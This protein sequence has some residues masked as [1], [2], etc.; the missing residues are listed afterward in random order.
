MKKNNKKEIDR[1]WSWLTQQ[2]EDGE[3]TLYFDGV[4]AQESWFEDEVSPEQFKKELEA[5]TGPVTIWINSPGGDVFAAAQIYN[6]LRNYKGKVTVKIDGIAASAATV[7]AMAGD[8][9][10]MSPVSMMMIHNP[11]TWAAGDSKDLETV[12]RQLDAV[13]ETIINAY[14]TK[15]GMDRDELSRLMDDEASFDVN[16]AIEHKFADGVIARRPIEENVQNNNTAHMFSNRMAVAAVMNKLRKA[17]KPEEPKGESP[18]V[19]VVDLLKE[20]EAKKSNF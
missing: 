9:V 20:L 7:I 17:P 10:L 5:G 2:N 14:E 1:F 6:M 3:R 15:T 13:K 16:W 8:E 12:I 11:W 19:K 18:N 4:I